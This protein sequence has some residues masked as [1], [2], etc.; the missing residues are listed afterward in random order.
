MI[1]MSEQNESYTFE[2]AARLLRSADPVTAIGEFHRALGQTAMEAVLDGRDG[3]SV[4]G[5]QKGNVGFIRVRVPAKV[6]DDGRWLL[7]RSVL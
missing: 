4:E 1:A 2:I 6:A 5:M 7:R 3:F